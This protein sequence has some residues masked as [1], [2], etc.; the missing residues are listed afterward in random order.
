MAALCPERL[1]LH[2]TEP[3]A[4]MMTC[5]RPFPLFVGGYGSGKTQ[6]K[7]WTAL[8]ECLTHPGLK[9]GLY[10]P[11]FQLMKLSDIPRIY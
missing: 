4:A 11:S 7:L 6:A 5:P 9:Y 2:P 1:Q 8:A 3:Q 10:A